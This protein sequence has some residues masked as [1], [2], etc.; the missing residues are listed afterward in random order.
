MLLA[1]LGPIA[2]AILPQLPTHKTEAVKNSKP[3][4]LLTC[5]G[6]A[7]IAVVSGLKETCCAADVHR[8]SI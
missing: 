1:R 8:E 3:Y 5:Y 6:H 4:P 2:Y 7:E